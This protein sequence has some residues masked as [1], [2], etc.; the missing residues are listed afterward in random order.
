MSRR[1]LQFR[2]ATLIFAILIASIAF[3]VIAPKPRHHL[4]LLRSS[5]FDCNDI[6]RAVNHYVEI[7]E[8]STLQE[9]ASLADEDTNFA[10]GFSINERIGWLC[11]VLYLPK[12]QPLRPPGYG[13]LSL[14]YRTMPAQ[15]LPLYPVAKSGETYCVLAEGYLLSGVAEPVPD[16][17]AY[18]QANG[19][20]RTKPVQVT[21]RKTAIR[22]VLAI[23]TST[24]W[25]AI[26]WTD[27]GPGSSYYMIDEPWTWNPIISQAESIP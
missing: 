15:K 2:L 4:R 3:A 17:L 20:F 27:S 13:A 7:G 11:R 24:R 5:E 22:D 9:L 19:A 6:A 8:A 21:D 16:Y 1:T 10:R 25:L 23:R 26:K 14:P 18:C 12:S